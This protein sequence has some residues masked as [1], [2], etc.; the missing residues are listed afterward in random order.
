[1]LTFMVVRAA[2]SSLKAET[3]HINVQTILCS[4][5]KKS[6]VSSHLTNPIFFYP[7]LNFFHTLVKTKKKRKKHGL[8]DDKRGTGKKQ[9]KKER[10]REREREK[11]K[12]KKTTY[13]PTQILSVL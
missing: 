8:A 7:L 13:V 4:K 6:L 5:E 10:E 11:E 1:M 9:T 12:E 3:F 2:K